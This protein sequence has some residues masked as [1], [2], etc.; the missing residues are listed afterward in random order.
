MYL[1]IDDTRPGGGRRNSRRQA[2]CAVVGVMY[3]AL[4]NRDF[5]FVARTCFNTE[6]ALTKAFAPIVVSGPV[7]NQYEIG[8]NAYGK[9]SMT[10]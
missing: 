7:G 8:H 9:A 1:Y 5:T 6:V 2:D 10:T 3:V 4:W